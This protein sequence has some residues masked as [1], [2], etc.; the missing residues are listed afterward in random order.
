MNHL[1]TRNFIFDLSIKT[2]PPCLY[3]LEKKQKMMSALLAKFLRIG[4]V[5]SVL[6]EFVTH[7]ILTAFAIEILLINNIF[8]GPR[9]VIFQFIIIDIF[10]LF[11]HKL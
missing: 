2:R 10:L 5:S 11:K 6:A 3:A 8:H 4:Q 7:M 9:S 1:I